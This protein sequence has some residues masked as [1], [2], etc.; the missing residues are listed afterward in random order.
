MKSHKVTVILYPGE[1][2]AYVS[3]VPLF[4]ECTTEGS[5]VEEALVNARESLQLHLEDAGDDDL[6]NIE[7]SY[8]PHVVV[9]QVDVA[10]PERPDET[11]HSVAGAGQVEARA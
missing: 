10:A 1:D 2:G 4:P 5:S 7:L 8:V 6:E 3:Y 11:E 9:G